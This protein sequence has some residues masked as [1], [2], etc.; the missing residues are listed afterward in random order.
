MLIELLAEIMDISSG[1]SGSSGAVA[2]SR[3]GKLADSECCG[4]VMVTLDE[5]APLGRVEV[6]DKDVIDRMV[7]LKN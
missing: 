3:E 7:R 6:L 1:S 5:L 4:K 2:I